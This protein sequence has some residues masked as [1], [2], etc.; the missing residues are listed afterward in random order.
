MQVP[1]LPGNNTT[2]KNNKQM[3][4]VSTRTR[5]EFLLETDA[6]FLCDKI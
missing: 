5:K 1:P 4:S 6:I 2:Q 3:L